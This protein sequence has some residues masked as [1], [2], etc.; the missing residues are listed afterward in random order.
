ME[1]ADVGFG[2]VRN[3]ARISSLGRDGILCGVSAVLDTVGACDDGDSVLLGQLMVLS[4][5][6][7][8]GLSV[9]IHTKEL[10]FIPRSSS[11][12]DL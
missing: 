12:A 1:T 7:C 5:T 8:M 10:D 6:R 4:H 9:H 2:W 3:C 11:Y